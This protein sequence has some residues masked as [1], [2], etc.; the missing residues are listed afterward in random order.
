MGLNHSV[1]RREF[2]KIGAAAAAGMV[3]PAAGRATA[4]DDRPVRIGYVGVGNAVPGSWGY[5]CPW[6]AS[7]YL[8]CATSTPVLP[9]ERKTLSRGRNVP[10]PNSIPAML[11]GNPNGGNL[12]RRTR[13]SSN[14]RYGRLASEII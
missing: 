2:L 4:D 6:K 11:T 1:A 13:R 12:S 9:P 14:I 8:R 7:K 3:F 10:S 5:W